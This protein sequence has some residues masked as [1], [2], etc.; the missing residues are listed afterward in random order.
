MSLA[1]FIS[2]SSKSS[3]RSLLWHVLSLFLKALSVSVENASVF[4]GCKNSNTFIQMS[5]LRLLKE[6][7]LSLQN[8]W[9][10]RYWSRQIL[11]KS[12]RTIFWNNCPCGVELNCEE[13]LVRVI[14]FPIFIVSKWRLVHGHH[15]HSPSSSSVTSPSRVEGDWLAVSAERTAATQCHYSWK[16]AMR[17]IAEEVSCV[18]CWSGHNKFA[19][20]MD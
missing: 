18:Q 6:K 13:E 15:V 11:Q 5:S 1:C 20:S 14:K 9:V 3:S 19:F 12:F 4:I 2:S 17:R 7:A 10:P 8:V 16:N